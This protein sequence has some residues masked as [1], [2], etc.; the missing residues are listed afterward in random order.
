[1]ST[2]AEDTV[3]TSGLFAMTDLYVGA[4]EQILECTEE[5]ELQLSMRDEFMT[6]CEMPDW[7]PE[8]VKKAVD[9]RM[10]EYTDEAFK[11]EGMKYVFRY[12]TVIMCPLSV[13]R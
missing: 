3:I 13:K 2:F 10:A 5:R 12:D 1:M 9:K 7:V 6:L 8:E 11:I 4:T